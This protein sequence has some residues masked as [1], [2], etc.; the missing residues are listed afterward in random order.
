MKKQWDSLLSTAPL[1][2]AAREQE[3]RKITD[4]LTRQ[5]VLHLP[6]TQAM[7]VIGLLHRIEAEHANLAFDSEYMKAVSCR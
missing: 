5:G 7:D 6:P 1:R 2:N 4:N 3:S